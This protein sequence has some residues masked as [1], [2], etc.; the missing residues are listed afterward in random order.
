M[1]LTATGVPLSFLECEQGGEWRR[2]SELYRRGL[3]QDNLAEELYRRLMICHHARGDL[4][5]AVN[6]Y[7]RCREMLWIVLG[8]PP[9]HETEALYRSLRH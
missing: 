4:G 6:V 9:A 2:A 5:E 7:R 8:V 1:V 3:E